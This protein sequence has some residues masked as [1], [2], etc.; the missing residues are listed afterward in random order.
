MPLSR[1]LS[2]SLTRSTYL[3]VPAHTSYILHGSHLLFF[4]RERRRRRF[5]LCL[6]ITSST[7]KHVIWGGFRRCT[8][9]NNRLLLLSNQMITTVKR[10]VT[11]QLS[12]VTRNCS[13]IVPGM[14]IIRSRPIYTTKFNSTKKKHNNNA[15]IATP[16]KMMVV[17]L[18]K[19][20]ADVTK[21]VDAL[22]AFELT[23]ARS[24]NSR[25]RE[26]LQQP[27]PSIRLLYRARAM[28]VLSSESKH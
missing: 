25:T 19:E 17:D 23:A 5:H 24:G 14:Y 8:D 27:P 7:P 22:R 1:A 4:Y 6:S 10:T 13:L 12:A 28:S 2:R 21:L 16:R 26:Q 18:K 15:Q 9:N 11:Q 3:C 20:N